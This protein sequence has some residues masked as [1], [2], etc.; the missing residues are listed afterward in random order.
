MLW[1]ELPKCV[2]SLKLYETALNAGI[3]IAPGMIFSSQQ[4]YR[5]FIRLNAAVWNDKI[6]DAV[7]TLGRLAK[8][9]C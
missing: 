2:D 9:I 8:E 1:I 7:A 6:K 3:T 5:N 4:R